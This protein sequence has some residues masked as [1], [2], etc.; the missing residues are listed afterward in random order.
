MLY[1]A[2]LYDEPNTL[3]VP[4]AESLEAIDLLRPTIQRAFARIRPCKGLA[5]M[6][7]AD[8]DALLE[9]LARDPD[10][11]HLALCYVMADVL[12]EIDDEDSRG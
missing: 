8:E 1:N 10:F 7:E 12:N 11:V 4:Q 5:A 6:T 3:V 9:E 2:D